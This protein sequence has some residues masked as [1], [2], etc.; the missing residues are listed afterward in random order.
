[1]LPTP[2]MNDIFRKFAHATAEAVGSPWAFFLSLAAIVL[3]AAAGPFF[4]FSD[5]WQLV[6]NTVTTV[7]TFLVVFLIQN[8]QNR[9]A[10][11]ILRRPPEAA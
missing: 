6:V 7:V 9:D 11:A 5:S 3:W 2:R 1:L 10:R 4:G 8:T